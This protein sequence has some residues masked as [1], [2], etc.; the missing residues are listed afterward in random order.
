M[1]DNIDDALV[2]LET[3][4]QRFRITMRTLHRWLA[5]DGIATVPIPGAKA[6]AARWGDIV[7]ASHD[8]PRWQIPTTGHHMP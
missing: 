8:T 2:P 1:T 4:A 5:A 6:Y 3:L 7:R